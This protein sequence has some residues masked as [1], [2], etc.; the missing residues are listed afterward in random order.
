VHAHAVILGD[1]LALPS[2]GH[3]PPV[4]G[5]GNADLAEMAAE[6]RARGPGLD[7]EETL[8][9]H[10]PDAPSMLRTVSRQV[11]CPRSGR[12]RRELELNTAGFTELIKDRLRQ[13]WHFS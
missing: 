10:Q 9:A 8:R 4:V 13:A 7:D 1:V 2:A 11:R 3:G 6:G 5:A 12:P